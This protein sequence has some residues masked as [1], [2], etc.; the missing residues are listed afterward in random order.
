MIEQAPG[1]QRGK[2][3]LEIVIEEKDGIQFL[4]IPELGKR[5]PVY[6]FRDLHHQ[7]LA[8]RAI[9]RGAKMAMYGGVWAGLAAEKRNSGGG[10]FFWE[11]KRSGK[12]SDPKYSERPKEAKP[13][14]M[15]RPEDALSLVD[16]SKHHPNVRFL[17][18]FWNFIKLWNKHPAYLHVIAAIRPTLGSFPEKFKTT[19]EEFKIRYPQAPPISCDTFASF[20]REDPFLRHFAT[21][22]ARFSHTQMYIGVSTLNPHG[23]EPPYSF[24]DF[25]EDIRTRRCR[26][27]LIDLIVKDD[28]Y[29]RFQV[30]GSHTQIRLPLLGEKSSFKVLRI[31]SF[32][33][34]A[35]ERATG[36]EC[37]LTSGVK[38][39]R[40]KPG[41]DLDE[42]LEAMIR[43]IREDL[44]KRK[45]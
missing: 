23:E 28:L 21:L 12:G 41:E 25:L 13:P 17:A 26:I 15:I 14:V 31:G 16:W 33:P 44:R 42:K 1:F 45:F 40:K 36:F 32:S 9:A 20:W 19:P 6:D 18:N 10:D 2:E 11:I 35:F 8:A 39:V 22:V 7:V 4:T 43:E 34:E 30:F 29:E 27:E 5:V 38:D 24:K 3:E 37:E